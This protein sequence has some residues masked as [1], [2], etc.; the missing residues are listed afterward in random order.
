VDAAV[1]INQYIL[2]LK[3]QQKAWSAKQSFFDL[4]N[5]VLIK[6]NLAFTK[7]ELKL[8]IDSVSFRNEIVHSYDVN[9]YIIWSK[10]NLAVIID[11][12]KKYIKKIKSLKL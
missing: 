6:K 10:R 8:L 12:Y 9:I 5:K 3:F 1:D 2:E 11:I 7:E 4:Q